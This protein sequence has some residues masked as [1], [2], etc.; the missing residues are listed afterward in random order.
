MLGRSGTICMREAMRLTGRSKNNAEGMRSSL[1]VFE[2]SIVGDP[3]LGLPN[4]D[5]TRY[6]GSG[7]RQSAL[8]TK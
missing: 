5:E 1:R 8:A 3:Y 7:L 4:R 2:S 6:I